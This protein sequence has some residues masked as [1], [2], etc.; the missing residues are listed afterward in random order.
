[1]VMF[2]EGIFL[3][4]IIRMVFVFEYWVMVLSIV[5]MYRLGFLAVGVRVCLLFSRL[6]FG[7]DYIGI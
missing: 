2:M 7:V 3:L 6:L 1:M 4:L 5:S